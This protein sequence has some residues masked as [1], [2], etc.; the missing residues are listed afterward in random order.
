MAATEPTFTVRTAENLG[1]GVVKTIRGTNRGNL[2]VAE[3]EPFRASFVRDRFIASGG[4]VANAVVPVVD[5]PTTAAGFALYNANPDKSLFIEKVTAHQAS[6]TAGLGGSLLVCKSGGPQSSPP[7]TNGT[8]VVIDRA[9]GGSGNTLC[10]FKDAVTL[11]SAGAWLTVATGK[12]I[13][14]VNIGFAMI[15]DLDGLIEIPPLYCLGMTV[16]APTGTNAKF[17]FGVV[18]SEWIYTAYS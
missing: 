8:G 2:A 1:S 14:E 16:L 9:G 17:T 13:A 11:T 15:A 18:W 5:V 7:T 4:V 12:Y 10:K 6:G 3:A